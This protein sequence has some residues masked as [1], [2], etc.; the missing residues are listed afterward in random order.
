[1]FLENIGNGL[2]LFNKT[3]P[4]L[5]SPPR[6]VP[7]SSASGLFMRLL[8]NFWGAQDGRVRSS[9]LCCSTVMHW[10]LQILLLVLVWLLLFPWNRWEMDRKKKAEMLVGPVVDPVGSP[11]AVTTGGGELT[12]FGTQRRKCFW[13]H[14]QN[15][16]KCLF[17]YVFHQVLWKK[18]ILKFG[19]NFWFF[20]K[21]LSKNSVC[22]GH[23]P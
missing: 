16:Q 9:Q 10:L 7:P 3:N 4:S 11:R 1:M 5:G 15:W 12:L 20:F 2:T 6:Q 22:D 23:T 19:K 21:E 13:P 14:L 17:L 18:F 8:I